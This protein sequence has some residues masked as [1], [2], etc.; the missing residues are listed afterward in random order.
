MAAL[1]FLRRIQE[2]VEDPPG[3]VVVTGAVVRRESLQGKGHVVRRMFAD[4][5]VD[6]YL[7]ADGDLTYEKWWAGLKQ[8]RSFVTNR[9]VLEQRFAELEKQY[10]AD[11]VPTP[12]HWHAI[13]AIAAANT[14]KDIWCEK[15]LSRTIAEGEAVV[16]AVARARVW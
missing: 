16:A 11:D 8:G 10:E 4:I 12:P 13:I 9:E 1:G 15:P 14:G 7:M 3:A 5:D 2:E 6:V